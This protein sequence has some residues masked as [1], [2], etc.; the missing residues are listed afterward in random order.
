MEKKMFM[1]VGELLA[2]TAK[3]F[4]FKKNTFSITKSYQRL[5]GKDVITDPKIPKSKR[6]ISI[7]DFLCEEM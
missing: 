4:D 1:R 6:I 5:K 2:L 7:P 3:D